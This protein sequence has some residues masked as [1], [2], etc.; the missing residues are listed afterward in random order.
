M[1]D[2]GLEYAVRRLLGCPLRAGRRQSSPHESGRPA[3]LLPVRPEFGAVGAEGG[4]LVPL[5]ASV[6]KTLL[7]PAPRLFAVEQGIILAPTFV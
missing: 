6:R 7:P 5:S 3:L 1:R 4:G 2:E